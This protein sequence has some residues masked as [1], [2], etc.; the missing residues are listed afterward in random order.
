MRP[1]LVVRHAADEAL[2]HV[3]IALR[4]AGLRLE[5]A[6]AFAGDVA[7]RQQAGFRTRDW[8]G[9]VVMGGP[10]NANQTDRYPYLAIE[11][12]WL[13][14]A[15]EAGLP[16]LGICLG[17]QLLAKALGARVYQ[18]PIKEI[19]WY[20]IELLA[21]SADPLLAGSSPRETVFQWHGDTF[22]PP[23][24]ATWLARGARCAQQAFRYGRSAWGVQFHPEMTAEMVG[25]WL[26]APSL[27]GDLESA[28]H[29][30]PDAIRAE[31]PEKFPA[32]RAFCDRLL[33][34][35]AAVCVSP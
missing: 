15:A 5:V 23:G 14:A 18:N 29:I 22:D 24:G 27:C 33:S 30:D 31:L 12:D 3:Q 4:A 10:M 35:F 34:N 11:V 26:T 7:S 6:E 21:A 20:E 28:R 19:G 32:M 1:V 25:D 17:G 13:R 9:L 2:G 8:S 16:T